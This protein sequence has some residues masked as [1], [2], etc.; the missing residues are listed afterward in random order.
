MEREG[1]DGTGVFANVL[2]GFSI[3]HESCDLFYLASG[4]GIFEESLFVH[5]KKKRQINT[6][7]KRLH[8]SRNDGL[9]RVKR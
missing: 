5:L 4:V 2:N 6:A 1:G 9:L 8:F 7:Q 3:S